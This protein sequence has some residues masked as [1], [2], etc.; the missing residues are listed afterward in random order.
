MESLLLFD[1]KL[2]RGSFQVYSERP[3]FTVKT[4][5]QIHSNIVV[6]ENNSLEE[7]D[8]IMSSTDYPL[9]ILTAD[10]IPLVLIGE[11]SH[12]VIHA[13][14]KGLQS[15][16]IN[17]PLVKEMNPIFAFIGPHIRVAQYEVQKEFK[18]NFPDSKFFVEK[19]GHL[20]FDLTKELITQLKSAYPQIKITDC[21]IDTLTNESF[22]SFRRNKTTKRNW[23]IYNPK[24][25]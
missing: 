8:G 12:A 2:L 22:A 3:D 18:E 13:G 14:W 17:N 1:R 9:A 10:C 16:I 6:K 25:H 4:V 11:K 5:K 21:E 20:F 15:Q 24:G 7:A 23:N 19:N